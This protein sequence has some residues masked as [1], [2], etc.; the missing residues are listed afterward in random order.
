MVFGHIRRLPNAV[1]GYIAL[2][3]AAD[4]RSG[5][6]FNGCPQWKQPRGRPINT[7]VRQMELDMD[8][9]ADTAWNIAADRD[10]WR[11]PGSTAGHAA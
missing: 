9:T 6:L 5:R 7:W 11:A 3:L 10:A 8:M 2:H 4:A 1:P